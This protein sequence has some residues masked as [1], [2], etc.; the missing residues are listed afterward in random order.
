M[1]LSKA[2][3][4]QRLT[5]RWAAQGN[6]RWMAGLYAGLVFVVSLLIVTPPSQANTPDPDFQNWLQALIADARAA[7]ISDS[8]IEQVLVPVTPIPQVISNDRNQAEFVE[9][10]AMYLENGSP[11][12]V[13]IPVVSAWHAMPM[14]WRRCLHNTV[15]PR[16]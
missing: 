10:L 16:V 1:R 15:C 5:A 4:S 12:G 2:T 8:L 7:G 14:C 6:R 13:S 3:R 9:T 11:P